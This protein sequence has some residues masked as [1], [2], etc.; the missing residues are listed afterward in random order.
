MNAESNLIERIMSERKESEMRDGGKLCD[1]QDR[2]K[3]VVGAL[4]SCTAGLY[5]ILSTS[6]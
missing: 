4:R 5:S 2:L 6:M 1:G 3:Q